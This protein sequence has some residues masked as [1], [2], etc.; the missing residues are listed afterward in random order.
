MADPFSRIE[1]YY[2]VRVDRFGHDFR[3]CDYGR[4]ESQSIK[5]EVLSSVLPL[6]GCKLL[7]VG[8]GFADYAGFLEQ[9]FGALKYV[10]IDLS[11]R[12]I[13]EAQR[14]RPDLDLRRCNLLDL[15][16]AEGFDVVSANGIFYLLGESALP[17][18]Q[19]MIERMFSLAK[20]AVALNS[21]S[22]WATD[23]EPNEFYADPAQTLD[24]CRRLTSRV[25]LRHDYHTRDFT[26]YLYKE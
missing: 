19:Q 11:P 16:T 23:Q 9:K 22:S 7:D 8:C 5:F 17:T 10:G 25:V 13:A 21:L 4:R 2:D 6:G 15:D 24:F 18:M 20:R 3:A 14:L 26:L 12:M 1:R